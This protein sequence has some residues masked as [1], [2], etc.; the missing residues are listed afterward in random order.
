MKKEK[1]VSSVEYVTSNPQAFARVKNTRGAIG[2]VGYGF[3]QSGVKAITL[4]GVKPSRQ[5]ILSGKY[6]VSRPLFMF[7]NGYPTLG[8][9]A[10]KFVTY[11]LTE[12]G[13]EVVEDKGFVA[14]TNY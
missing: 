11:H 1:M 13:Q 10:H 8:S 7:T 9:M 2:Y 5:T 6:P 14:V 12:E 4:D 3:V